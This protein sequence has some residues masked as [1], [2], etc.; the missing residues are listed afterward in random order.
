[1]LSW[2]HEGHERL[3]D[4]TGGGIG[5][6]ELASVRKMLGLPGGLDEAEKLVEVSTGASRT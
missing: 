5:R 6:E 4:S 2:R 1:M 3:L